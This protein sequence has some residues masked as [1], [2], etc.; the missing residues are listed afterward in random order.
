MRKLL[1][2]IIASIIYFSVLAPMG[3][4]AIVREF[5]HNKVIIFISIPMSIIYIYL[6]FKILHKKLNSILS[7]SV[8]FRWVMHDCADFSFIREQIA[9]E[10]GGGKKS[11]AAHASGAGNVVHS[12]QNRTE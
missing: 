2:F 4:P 8:F 5:T 7:R 12:T 1:R 11:D 6:Y 9:R 10:N 3:L